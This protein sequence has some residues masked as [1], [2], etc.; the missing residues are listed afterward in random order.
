MAR[1]LE[2][3]QTMIESLVDE[4]EKEKISKLSIFDE[5]LLLKG[6]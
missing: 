1:I 5:L 4:V 2:E 3:K 6:G